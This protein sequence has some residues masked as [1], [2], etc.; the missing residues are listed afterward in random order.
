MQFADR[1]FSNRVL[2]IYWKVRTL[3]YMGINFLNFEKN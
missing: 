3:L 2:W 1:V